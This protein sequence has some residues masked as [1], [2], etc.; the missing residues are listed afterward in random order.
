MRLKEHKCAAFEG[1][2]QQLRYVYLIYLPSKVSR[3]GTPVLAR[4]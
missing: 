4:R 2:G 3:S 1:F